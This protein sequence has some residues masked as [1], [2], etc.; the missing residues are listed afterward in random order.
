MNESPKLMCGASSAG[1]ARWF[2]MQ[3]HRWFPSILYVVTIIQPE[4]LSNPN[5]GSAVAFSDRTIF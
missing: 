4:T 3:L 5:K 2:L 1:N